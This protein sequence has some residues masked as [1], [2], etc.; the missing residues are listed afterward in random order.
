MCPPPEVMSDRPENHAP[1]AG[2]L[3]TLL[4]AVNFQA[5]VIYFGQLCGEWTIDS[6]ASG[7]ESFHVVGRG[8][9]WLHMTSFAEPVPLSPGDIVV[10]PADAPHLITETRTVP[11]RAPD[12]ASFEV[13]MDAAADGTALVCGYFDVSPD[14]RRLLST[15]LP[16]CLVVR[17]SPD[18]DGDRMK[19]L[20]DLLFI[21][22]S[23]SRDGTSAILDRLVD[24]LLLY[25]LRHAYRSGNVDRGILAGLNDPALGRVIEAVLRR[26]EARW[27]VEIMAGQ[28]FL[29]RS[30]FADRFVAVVGRAPMDF[31]TQLR[32][33]LARKWLGEQGMAVAEVA[34]RCGYSTEASFAKAFK[35]EVGIGPGAWRQSGKPRGLTGQ[36]AI[37]LS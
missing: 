29:S 10:F 16:D 36:P 34:E 2:G 1:M 19:H 21:E 25:V 4:R 15:A 30:A 11:R 12:V 7:A 28:A 22:A 8:A 33:S 37:T 31:V 5:K 13:P 23:D 17:P 20:T 14:A 6:V 3:D 18:S 26:P 9:P 35:R 32:M 27:T 24:V